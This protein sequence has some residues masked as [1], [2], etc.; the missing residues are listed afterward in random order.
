MTTQKYKKTGYKCLFDEQE[1]SQKLAHIGNP[2]E[3]LITCYEIT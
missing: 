1:T 2:F 3:M